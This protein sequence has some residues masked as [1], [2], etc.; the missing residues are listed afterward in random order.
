[1]LYPIFAQVR[2]TK[3]YAEPIQEYL[4]TEFKPFAKIARWEKSQNITITEKLDGTNAS[5]YIGPDGEFRTGSRNRWITPASDN[6]GFSRWAHE[7]KEELLELGEGLHFGEWWGLGIQRRY[8]LAEKRFS[9]FEARRWE[10]SRP[11]CCGVVPILYSGRH[12][13]LAITTTMTNLGVEGSVAAPG[14]MQ[15]EGVIIYHVAS[16]IHYKKTFE[17][18]GGKHESTVII[19]PAK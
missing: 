8:G 11:A 10:W 6:Y 3:F 5:I 4:M 16:G 14:F 15:P 19:P 7:H 13:D 1:L 18:D 17:H 2:P 12:T 9:L